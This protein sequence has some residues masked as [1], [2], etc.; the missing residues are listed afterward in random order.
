MNPSTAAVLLV[1]IGSLAG[2]AMWQA[3]EARPSTPGRTPDAASSP[4]ANALIVASITVQAPPRQAPP[5]QAFK[6]PAMP[7]AVQ[8]KDRRSTRT[9]SMP[10][11][12]AG[13]AVSGAESS[14]VLFGRGRVV[15]LHGPGPLDDEY[16]VEAVFDDYLVLRHIPTG[17]GQFLA[18]AQRQ[19]VLE[20]SQDP[21]DSP[22]D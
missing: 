4:A 20:L 11:R 18:F 9:S 1:L 7:A 8:P 22:R 5:P 19:P 14:I 6:A 10:Y 16:V 13:R 12:F 21:E 2:V 15:T 3:P 17:V